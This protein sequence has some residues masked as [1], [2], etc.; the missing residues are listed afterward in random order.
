MI[1]RT[2]HILLAFL[3]L[4][5]S[6]LPMKGPREGSELRP[7]ALSVP[8]RPCTIAADIIVIAEDIMAFNFENSYGDI[9]LS[10]LFSCLTELM[11]IET[12]H[13]FC[14]DGMFSYEIAALLESN[15]NERIGNPDEI[16]NAPGILAS[17]E[18]CNRFNRAIATLVTHTQTLL[19]VTKQKKCFNIFWPYLHDVLEAIVL[20]KT[21]FPQYT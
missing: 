18:T 14:R 20:V 10:Y 15:W 16:L 19:A 2:M 13:P 12:E 5:L 11:G 7:T 6:V 8:F 9:T 17:S 3:L 1:S 21:K 4:P